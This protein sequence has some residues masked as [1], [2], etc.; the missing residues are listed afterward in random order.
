MP[1]IHRVITLFALSLLAVTP[2]SLRAD[3]K[4]TLDGVYFLAADRGEAR[5]LRINKGRFDIR[6]IGNLAGTV[7]GYFSGGEGGVHFIYFNGAEQ[8]RC[9][10]TAAVIDGRLWVGVFYRDPH[11][12]DLFAC[13]T[14]HTGLFG[15]EQYGMPAGTIRWDMGKSTWTLTGPHDNFNKSTVIENVRVL[16]NPLDEKDR[17]LMPVFRDGDREK[18][19][20]IFRDEGPRNYRDWAGWWALGAGMFVDEDWRLEEK[21]K[22]AGDDAGQRKKIIDTAL[23]VNVGRRVFEQH[24]DVILTPWSVDLGP[25]GLVPAEVETKQLIGEYVAVDHAKLRVTIEEPKKDDPPP[26][27]RHLRPGLH[28]AEQWRALYST[29]ASNPDDWGVHRRVIHENCMMGH[30]DYPGYDFWLPLGDGRLA[31]YLIASTHMPRLNDWPL[32]RVIVMKKVTK[33][34]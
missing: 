30:I 13:R 3:E 16:R 7:S 24:G 10:A 32:G 33:N 15:P 5:L 4:P 27:I 29:L 23:R 17:R 8:V 6:L 1:H 14:L 9:V 21:L 31:R 19:E 12:K 25:V 20:T 22:E 28:T 26:H 2:L 11:Q 34:D 18:V